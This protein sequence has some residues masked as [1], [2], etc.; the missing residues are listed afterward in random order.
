[1]KIMTA[2]DI[3]NRFGEFLDSAQR[4][5]ILVTKNNR[6]VGI[7]ISV[8]DAAESLAAHVRA[9]K[10][11]PGYDAWLAAKVTKS[12]RRIDKG[13]AELIEHDEAVKRLKAR[14]AARFAPVTA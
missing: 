14:L 8:E 10:K 3:K 4:E 6:P 7:M 11:A 13:K 2:R 9:G 1:M 12:M 5:P